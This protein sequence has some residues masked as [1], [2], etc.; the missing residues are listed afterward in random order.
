MP[1]P[2]SPIRSYASCT[3]EDIPSDGNWQAQDGSIDQNFL[4]GSHHLVQD[5]D[6]WT[7]LEFKGFD[8]AVEA[9]VVLPGSGTAVSTG[10]E[11]PSLDDMTRSGVHLVD[12]GVVR[13]LNEST[14]E[15]VISQ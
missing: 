7:K 14:I 15:E 1:P 13:P 6:G 8:R 3:G 10:I 2:L 9:Q 11:I 12:G 4:L 5:A